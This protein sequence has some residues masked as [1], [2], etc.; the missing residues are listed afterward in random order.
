MRIGFS[1]PR[2]LGVRPWIS[3]G[4]EDGLRLRGPRSPLAP[5]APPAAARKSR[6]LL[7]LFALALWA[8]LLWQAAPYLWPVFIL[9]RR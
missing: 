2:V 3:F 8:C 7:T 6:P 9:L 5:L 4:A 1:G